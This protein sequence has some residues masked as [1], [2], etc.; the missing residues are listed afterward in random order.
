MFDVTQTL[1]QDNLN[2]QAAMDEIALSALLGMVVHACYMR[3]LHDSQHKEAFDLL[4]L[5][6]LLLSERAM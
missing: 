1:V 5:S 4:C 6:Y 2:K 3:Q